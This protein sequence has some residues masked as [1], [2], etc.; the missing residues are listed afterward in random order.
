M[1]EFQD[2]GHPDGDGTENSGGY[3]WY[4]GP[5]GTFT[6][7]QPK[8]QKLLTVQNNAGIIIVPER[9]RNLFKLSREGGDEMTLMIPIDMFQLMITMYRHAKMFGPEQGIGLL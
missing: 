2:T 3:H 9:Y 5:H 7:R 6:L 1:S 8:P 4:L